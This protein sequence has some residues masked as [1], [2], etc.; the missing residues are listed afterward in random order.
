MCKV[1]L[2]KPY[3][4]TMPKMPKNRI[5]GRLDSAQGLRRSP[6]PETSRFLKPTDRAPEPLEG[7]R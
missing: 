6:C 2:T 3:I 1:D 4:E 5:P 7:Q